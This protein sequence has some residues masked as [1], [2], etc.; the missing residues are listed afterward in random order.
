LLSAS[1]QAKYNKIQLLKAFS[2]RLQPL[3]KTCFML[4]VVARLYYLFGQFLA[5]WFRPLQTEQRRGSGQVAALCLK[6][7]HSEQW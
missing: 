1:K 6:L 2:S 4:S 7:P 3:L 5:S